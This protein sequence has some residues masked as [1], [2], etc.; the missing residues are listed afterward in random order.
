MEWRA[1]QRSNLSTTLTRLKRCDPFLTGSL[2]SL[3]I[4]DFTEIGYDVFVLILCHLRTSRYH[5]RLKN[6]PSRAWHTCVKRTW[7]MYSVVRRLHYRHH[8]FVTV[9]R[10]TTIRNVPDVRRWGVI[11]SIKRLGTRPEMVT[12]GLLP[13][14][15][16]VKLLFWELVWSSSCTT[17]LSS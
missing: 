7:S 3:V 13:N 14:P 17:Y 16:A 2:M 5:S 6:S 15:V 9:L 10:S 4:A 11:S 8:E 1:S 12:L